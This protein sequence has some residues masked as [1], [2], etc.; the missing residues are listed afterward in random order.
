MFV[1]SKGKPKTV[2]LIKDRENK[3]KAP[4]GQTTKRAKDGSLVPTKMSKT[5]NDFGVRFNVWK[6]NIG[7]VFNTKSKIAKEHP[8][9]FPDK[10]AED[11]I[12]SWSKEGEIILDPFAGSGTTGIMSEKLNRKFIMVEINEE[13]CNLMQRRFKEQCNL[14]VEVENI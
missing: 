1:F 5:Y 6:Y 3:W 12:K 11:H 2:N 8:A 14:S 10:L 7:S 9:K 13:Y 4:W